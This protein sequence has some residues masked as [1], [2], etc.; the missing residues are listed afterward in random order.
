MK[1]A[2]NGNSAFIDILI[3]IGADLNDVNSSGSTVLMFAASNN[4]RV[5]KIG[6]PTVIG[7]G[8]V[9]EAY[10]VRVIFG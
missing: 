2:I 5:P 3:D 8:S 9:N 7:C 10:V 1:A 4:H 6:L